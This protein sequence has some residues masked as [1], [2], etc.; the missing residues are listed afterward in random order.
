MWNK[1]YQFFS[2]K[3]P[4][5]PFKLI[6]KHKIIYKLVIEAFQNDHKSLKI[7]HL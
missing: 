7:S 5:T 6:I 3:I 2:I 4:N 1:A